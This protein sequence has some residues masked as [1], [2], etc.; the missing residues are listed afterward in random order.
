LEI[1][2]ENER[3]GRTQDGLFDLSLGG[4]ENDSTLPCSDELKTL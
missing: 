1:S 3:S 2:L 4:E